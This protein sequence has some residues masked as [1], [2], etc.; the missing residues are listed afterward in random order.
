MFILDGE[1]DEDSCSSLLSGGEGRRVNERL[2]LVH[3]KLTKHRHLPKKYKVNYKV[4]YGHCTS[5]CVD[6]YV[7]V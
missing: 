1:V 4:C 7:C 3:I 2:T 5:V 6:A